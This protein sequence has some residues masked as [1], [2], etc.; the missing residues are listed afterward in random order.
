M[1]EV[2]TDDTF[3]S[4]KLYNEPNNKLK[5]QSNVQEICFTEQTTSIF[6]LTSLKG[7]ATF[8]KRMQT[9]LIQDFLK[10]T[11]ILRLNR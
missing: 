2:V 7:T 10:T 9:K 5:L 3:C 11:Q 8:K 4:I 1:Q 6:F